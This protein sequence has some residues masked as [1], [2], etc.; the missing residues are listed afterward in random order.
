M[1]SWRGY[2]TTEDERLGLSSYLLPEILQKLFVEEASKDGGSNRVWAKS[3]A[4]ARK[5]RKINDTIPVEIE[6]KD[7][8]GKA[9]QLSRPHQ[10][11]LE[12]HSKK[13]NKRYSWA[14]KRASSISAMVNVQKITLSIDVR[15]SCQDPENGH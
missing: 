12:I 13:S 14:R 1:R 2:H 3:V 7:I 8:G 15:S 4:Q 10:Q 5:G 9:H 6:M 11:S